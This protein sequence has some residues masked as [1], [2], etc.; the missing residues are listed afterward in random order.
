MSSE[1]NI[2]CYHNIETLLTY[3]KALLVLYHAI[4]ALK[5]YDHYNYSYIVHAEF[6]VDWQLIGQLLLAELLLTK[7][8]FLV[9][10]EL[11]EVLRQPLIVVLDYVLKVFHLQ[12][13]SEIVSTADNNPNI[14][15]QRP[16]C[17]E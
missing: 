11:V 4:L 8:P 1:G 6:P 15:R 7:T 3:R 17:L 13:T 5:C 10:I 9:Q 16:F 14:C 12:H 2:G